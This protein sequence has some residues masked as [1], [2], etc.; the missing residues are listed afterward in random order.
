LK[1][2]FSENKVYKNYVLSI[3][4][5]KGFDKISKLYLVGKLKTSPKISKQITSLISRGVFTNFN[6]KPYSV[7]AISEMKTPILAP[8]LVNV[9]LHGIENLLNAW[10]M[11]Q[12]LFNFKYSFCNTKL[13][14]GKFVS[15]VRYLNSFIVMHENLEILV[16]VKKKLVK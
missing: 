5:T 6:C 9:V 15:I 16:S 7:T 1:K 12:N 13:K 3:D 10:L 8:F 2:K 4:L 11:Q 14:Q